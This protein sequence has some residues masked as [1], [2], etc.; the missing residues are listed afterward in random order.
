M[1][2]VLLRASFSSAQEELQINLI[3]V[4]AEP[5]SKPRRPDYINSALAVL[6]PAH[7]IVLGVCSLMARNNC[8]Q[9]A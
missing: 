9:L 3:G 2:L 1:Y 8:Y 4:S 7:E 5:V 6:M